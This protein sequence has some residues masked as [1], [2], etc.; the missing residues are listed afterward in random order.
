MGKEN[1]NKLLTRLLESLKDDFDAEQRTAIIQELRECTPTDDA[2]LGAKM[3]LEENDWD[4]TVLKKAFA[5][6]EL[7]ISIDERK[8]SVSYL[9]YVK[10][11]A[12]LLPIALLVGYFVITL[13]SQKSLDDYYI[14]EEGLPNMM[15]DSVSNW[16]DLMELY[17]NDETEKAYQ[18]SEALILQKPEND[19][20]IYFHGVIA[21]DLKKFDIAEQEFAKC[22]AQKESVFAYDAAFRLGFVKFHLKKT[23]EA[24]Q[25]FEKVKNDAD[26]PYN[27]NAEK[28]LSFFN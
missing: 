21:Y 22:S 1:Q 12:V 19:T 5:K 20:A 3:L 23:K 24:Q 14:K 26:N 6:A 16:Y 4:Y 11:A 10:Y 28:A 18:L 2:L 15:S 27:V 13:N 7:R 8:Q 9:A 17:R 25:Q